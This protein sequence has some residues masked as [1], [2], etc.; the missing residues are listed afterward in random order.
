MK[1]QGKSVGLVGW[2]TKPFTNEKLMMGLK[3][4]LRIR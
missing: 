2:I 4:V 3:R 1:A